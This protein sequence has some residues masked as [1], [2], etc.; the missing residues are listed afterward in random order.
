MT[1]E[2]AFWVSSSLSKS[3]LLDPLQRGT[4]RR[5]IATGITLSSNGRHPQKEES[6]KAGRSSPP[7][8]TRLMEWTEMGGIV[9]ERNRLWLPVGT[10]PFDLLFLAIAIIAIHNGLPQRTLT[11]CLAVKL[12]CLC[13]A[14]RETVWPFPPL[15]G[16]G[17]YTPSKGRPLGEMFYKTEDPFYFPSSLSLALSSVFWLEFLTASLHLALFKNWAS[18]PWRDDYLRTLVCPL[19]CQPASE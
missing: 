18:R 15:K 10:V 8:S 11:L 14:H 5:H 12:K 4:K 19:L 1:C 9:V 13:S 3:R 2:A 16:R 17:E 7:F 6:D